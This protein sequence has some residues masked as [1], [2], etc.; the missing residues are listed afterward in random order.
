MHVTVE[1]RVGMFVLTA[2]A[3]LVYLG[4]QVGAFH[5]DATS[6]SS[7]I[8]QCADS[9]GLS[10]K[11]EV[12]IAGVKVGWIKEIQL[13]DGPQANVT[14]MVLKKYT[15]YRNARAVVRSQSL[16]GGKYLEI[17]PGD[18]GQE[19]L[20][21]GA[22]LA[23]GGTPAPTVDDLLK[24]FNAIAD[25]VERV[26]ASF[27][28]VFGDAQGA[29][30][31]KKTFD[32]LSATADRLASFSSTLERVFGRNE[33]QLDRFLHIGSDVNRLADRLDNDIFP[34]FKESIARISDVFDR[35]FCRIATRLES[36]TDALE[37]ACIQARDG[38]GQASCVA[39]KINDG[40][41]L[42]GK[43]VNDDGPYRDLQ[44]ATQGL[45]NYF[46]KM[47]R[48]QL[49]F[50]AHVESMHRPAENYNHSDA[51]GY[52]DVR[53]HPNED[54]F[55]QLQ[56][57]SSERGYRTRHDVYKHYVDNQN[58]PID[59]SCM[60]LDDV[61]KLRFIYNEKLDVYN[62]NT[63]KLGFQFGKIFKNV[64]LRFGLFEGAAG[65]A[66]DVDMP[67]R[68]E[69]FRWLTSL[70]AFDF[71]GWNR[72]DDRRPH[73]KWLNRMYLM[74]NIYL[75]FGADD[76]AS[77]RNANVFFGAGIRFGD[78]DAKMLLGGMGGAGSMATGGRIGIRTGTSTVIR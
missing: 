52:F 12:K 3:I 78:D 45:R 42:L 18:P 71:S 32:N 73:L 65:L 59:T 26:T 20:A 35:D 19:A 53:L 54:N 61:D 15:L 41:G 13:A 63:L 5:F 30:Q 48:M 7:Y 76:F 11:A 67:V 49:V 56:L 36:T 1:T 47:D 39:K 9:N 69:N 28:T 64:A 22:V 74:R 21:S 55:Y 77:K 14:I 38:I 44:Y 29:E 72:Q 10:K 70:E 46:A 58:R 2:L 66:L 33:E 51:K 43:L 25:N 16:L 75:T 50:D 24:K 23:P 37:Q 57:V 31:G 4:F 27:C 60:K 17:V 40:S 62:R 68:T 34:S 6:Y 8:V